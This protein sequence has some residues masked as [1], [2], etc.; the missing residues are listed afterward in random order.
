MMKKILLTG[1]NGF[2]G[3]AFFHS[4]KQKYEIFS[5]VRHKR[6]ED[7]QNSHI[8]ECDFTS[9]IFDHFPSDIDAIVHLAQSNE[10]RN[11]P[12]KAHDIFAVNVASTAA[13]LEWATKEKVKNFI[14]AS[15]GSVYEPYTESLI[16]SISSVPES[17]YS[18]TKRSAELLCK[19]YEKFLS[20]CIFRLFFPYGEG[21][22]DKL[23][24]NLIES[25]QTGKEITLHGTEGMLLC[26]TYIKDLIDI[27]DEAL[28]K[29]WN[30]IY[31]LANAELI[32]LKT[33]C[34]KIGKILGKQPKFLRGSGTSLKIQPSLKKLENVFDLSNFHSVD[35]GL[36]KMLKNDTKIH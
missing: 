11:F 33:L 12:E 16:E 30:G 36:K 17:Y 32:S 10:Y 23:I 22:K 25:I 3:Q 31:N 8:I 20:I 15:T 14:L 18:I 19:P 34:E 4:L 28:M 24:P 13:L 6:Q 5:V 21:Q 7:E 2:I 29:N 1:A 9:P 27:F 35:N 26:P